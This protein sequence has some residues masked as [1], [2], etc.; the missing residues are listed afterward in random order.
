MAASEPVRVIQP[1]LIQLPTRERRRAGQVLGGGLGGAGLGGSGG[2]A[3]AGGGAAVVSGDVPGAVGLG[4]DMTARFTPDRRESGR[5]AVERPTGNVLASG[6]GLSTVFPLAD[7][8]FR[9]R[10]PH[11]EAAGAKP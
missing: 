6:V 5:R 2:L 1:R 9:V 11:T 8:S 7:L 4:S 10:A 3:G